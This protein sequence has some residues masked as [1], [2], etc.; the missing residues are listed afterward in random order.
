MSSTR[1]PGVINSLNPERTNSAISSSQ[2]TPDIM[3]SPNMT[4][5]QGTLYKT[6]K[7]QRHRQPRHHNHW[8]HN[9]SHNQPKSFLGTGIQQPTKTKNRHPSKPNDADQ[10]A[11]NRKTSRPMKS[12]TNY[13][14]SESIHLSPCKKRL[15]PQSR[16]ST[17]KQEI[18][19]TRRPTPACKNTETI[20]KQRAQD[21]HA[22]SIQSSK[23]LSQAPVRR[24][25]ATGVPNSPR[26]VLADPDHI[27][28]HPRPKAYHNP[29]LPEPPAN[30]AEPENHQ[31]VSKPF[32]STRRLAAP[33]QT[34][35]PLHE[36][37][38]NPLNHYTSKTQ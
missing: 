21:R 35:T 13:T 2:H 37:L 16:T 8:L 36:T 10:A 34:G 5:G 12:D 26:T 24:P 7:P 18:K 20:N 19:W 33:A 4:Q 27:I 1:T 29:N 15:H 23:T 38:N 22:T 25:T 9:Q 11:H 6:K 17:K 32:F 31:N 3:P 28:V 30:S 14:E